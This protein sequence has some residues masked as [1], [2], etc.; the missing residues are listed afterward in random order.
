MA[1]FFSSKTAIVGTVDIHKAFIYDI[2]LRSKIVH[3]RND[4]L[5][6]QRPRGQTR[7]PMTKIFKMELKLVYIAKISID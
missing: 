6:L 3:S 4:A 5:R 2:H 1:F 7:G